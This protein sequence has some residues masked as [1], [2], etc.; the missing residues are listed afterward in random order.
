MTT[1][2]LAALLS[3]GLLLTIGLREAHAGGPTCVSLAALATPVTEN[4]DTLAQSGTT[5]VLAITG[6]SLTE[7]GGG[8]RDNEQYAADTGASNTGDTYSYGAAAASDRAL[9]GLQSGT[10]IPVFGA[11]FVNDTGTTI[12]SLDIAYRGEQWRLGT[13]GRADRIDFQ[14]STDALSLV[15]GTW[16][17]QDA[18]DFAT[19]N[20]VTIGAKDGNAVGNFTAVSS[21][22]TGLTL[23]SGD[24]IFIRWNDLNASGADDGLS[25]DDFSITPQGAGGGTSADLVV[26]KTDSADPANA[27]AALDYTITLTNNGPDPAAMVSVSDTV[28]AGLSI[29]GFSTPAG[30]ACTAPADTYTCTIASLPV[31][32]TNFTL[33]TLIDAATAGGTVLSNTASAT[34]TTTDPTPGDASDTETT[35]VGTSADLSVTVTDTPDPVQPGAALT[36][37]INFSNAGPSDAAGATLSDTLPAGTTFGSL[38]TAAGWSCTTPAVGGTGTVTCSALANVPAG[39]PG[40]ASFTLVVDVDPGVAPGTMIGNTATVA[41]TTSD[42]AP[43][44]GSATTTTTVAA[45]SA[46]LQVSKTAAP[47]PVAPS[48]NLTYTITVD[49]IGPSNAAG[50]ALSDTLPGGTTFVSLAAPGGWSCT[51]PAVGA[52]GTVNCSNPSMAVAGEVFTLVVQVG[53]GVAPGTV[54]SNTATVTSTTSDPLPGNESA[55]A[56]ATVGAGSADLSITKTAAPEPVTAGANLTYT[57]TASNAGPSNASSAALTDVL[58][59]GTTFVSLASPGGWS[60]TTPA[61]GATGAVSC[62]NASMAIAS[63]VFTLVVQVD[64]GAAGGTVL[65]NTATIA[66]ATTDPNPGNESATANSTVSAPAAISGTKSAAGNLVPGGSVTYTIVLSNAAVTGQGDN[67]GDEF[68]DVLPAGLTLVSATASSGTAVASI[69]TNTVTWNGSIAGNSSVTI[70]IDANIDSNVI[71][72]STITNQGTINFDADGNGSNESTTLTDNPATGTALDGTAIVVLGIATPVP[73]MSDWSRLLLM[74]ALALAAGLAMR[75]RIA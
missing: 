72:G 60:C 32:T 51:T 65:S 55:T 36:Y 16:T 30:W 6:W 25:V 45:G 58:P 24:T 54:I 8:A 11:C 73:G 4:F 38:T 23:G 5:N 52:T 2:P 41:A 53:P 3:S 19:P 37:T 13:A 49:N 31:G 61:V 10:L 33:N 27:G 70:T 40:D 20:Q 44:N 66:S 67:P 48:G 57:I 17:D 59:T 75:R 50:A 68:V 63:E 69:G 62:S 56:M 47:D 18:L 64:S 9:G 42:P 39:A 22:L 34:S 14:F 21:S 28:P 12:T 74:A 43:G 26:T 15:T 35:T 46:D 1:K 71:G 7:T 29:T